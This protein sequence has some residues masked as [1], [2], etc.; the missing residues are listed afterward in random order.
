MLET[1]RPDGVHRPERARQQLG[2]LIPDVANAQRKQ[3]PRQRPAFARG[4]V[5]E[6]VLGALVAHALEH[7]QLLPGELVDVAGVV[8]QLLLDQRPR[9]LFADGFD[10]H[11]PAPD[12]MLQQLE[13]LRPALRESAGT[14]GHGLA[15]GAHHV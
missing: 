3:H 11:R 9:Q 15:F 5:V 14:A 8:D 4:D 6:Q 10:V 1:R 13:A 7:D 2:I 12:K